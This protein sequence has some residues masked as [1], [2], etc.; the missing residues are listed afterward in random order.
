MGS[1]YRGEEELLNTN[2]SS[3]S[4]QDKNLLLTT[5]ALTRAPGILLRPLWGAS[6]TQ[7]R[8]PSTSLHITRHAPPVSLRTQSLPRTYSFTMGHLSHHQLVVCVVVADPLLVLPGH[9]TP[10]SRNLQGSFS[11]WQG[12]TV[13]DG[14][15]VRMKLSILVRQTWWWAAVRKL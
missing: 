14:C 13:E 12:L 7:L 1:G 8:R 9:T 5:L 10:C 4:A 15:L 6:L 11:A 2:P 3:L